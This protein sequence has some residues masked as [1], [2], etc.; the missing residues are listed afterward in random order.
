MRLH[1]DIFINMYQIMVNFTL[2]LLI[3]G[4]ENCTVNKAEK[5]IFFTCFS[6]LYYITT[7]CGLFSI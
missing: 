6:S 1:V 2:T 4:K 5:S 3:T 7:V